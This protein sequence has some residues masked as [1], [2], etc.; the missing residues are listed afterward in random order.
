MKKIVND[1]FDES[2]QLAILIRKPVVGYD[3]IN[4]KDLTKYSSFIHTEMKQSEVA[5]LRKHITTEGKS[6]FNIA[7]SSGFPKFNTN[8]RNAFNQARAQQDRRYI[9]GEYHSKLYTTNHPG[10]PDATSQSVL[11]KNNFQENAMATKNNLPDIV[12]DK[13]YVEKTTGEVF[14]EVEKGR[15]TQ[16]TS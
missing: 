2:T 12:D 4:S 14:T 15:S 6:V 1:D 9:F 7:K 8:F 5:N 11:V 10:E 13:I 3:I 16:K